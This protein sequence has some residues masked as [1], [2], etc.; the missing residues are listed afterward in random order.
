MNTEPTTKLGFQPASC[1]GY[2]PACRRAHARTADHAR[3]D[4]QQMAEL[5][6]VTFQQAHKY[7]MGV[8]RVGSR[9]LY[10]IAQA[11][12]TDGGYFFEGMGRDDVSRSRQQQRL[13]AE[14]ARNFVAIPIR[15][16]REEIVSLAR[17]LAEPDAG[18]LAGRDSRRR[19]GGPGP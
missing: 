13:L 6:G 15:R 1:G 4:L 18:P 17:T 3:A 16:H 8:N 2:R 19:I 5:I 9:R 7:E 12:D 11:S 10:Q 14:L